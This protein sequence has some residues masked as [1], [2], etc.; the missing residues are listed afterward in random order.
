M[1]TTLDN[2]LGYSRHIGII[3]RFTAE[4]PQVF[5]VVGIVSVIRTERGPLVYYHKQITDNKTENSVSPLQ[6]CPLTLAR[7]PTALERSK[8]FPGVGRLFRSRSQC[9]LCC[10][11]FYSGSD[12][13]VCAMAQYKMCVVYDN[14]R[15]F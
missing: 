13:K 3:Q 11:K 5:F 1:Q 9:G 12:C 7:D 15:S 10:Y 2:D 8:C 4:D 6:M 14:V